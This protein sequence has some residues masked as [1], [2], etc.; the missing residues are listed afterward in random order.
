MALWKALVGVGKS[1]KNERSI[2]NLHKAAGEMS[3]LEL[4]KFFDVVAE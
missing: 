4:N 2:L 3:D 1:Q